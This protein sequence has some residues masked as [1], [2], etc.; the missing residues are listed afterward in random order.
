MLLLFFVKQVCCPV[1]YIRHCKNKSKIISLQF[2]IAFIGQNKLAGL[3]Q[4][5]KL[6]HRILHFLRCVNNA[7]DIFFRTHNNYV[8]IYTASYYK[9]LLIDTAQKSPLV[10]QMFLPFGRSE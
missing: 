9:I 8:G 7:P 6:L 5:G 10:Y 2:P 4:P 3:Y 1:K